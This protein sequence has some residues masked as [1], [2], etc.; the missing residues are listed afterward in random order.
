MDQIPTNNILFAGRTKE[1]WT[2]RLRF[3]ANW[4]YILSDEEFERK[5]VPGGKARLIDFET[6][7]EAFCDWQINS[8]LMRYFNT[9]CPFN[10]FHAESTILWYV[11]EL[12]GMDNNRRE[13]LDTR[14]KA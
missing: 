6:D 5:Y 2:K 11:A 12:E 9:A 13:A 1:E 4:K 10:K 3:E 8:A 14:T 7:R